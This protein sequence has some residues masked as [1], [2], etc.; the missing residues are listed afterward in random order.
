MLYPAQSSRI[1][2][3]ISLMPLSPENSEVPPPKPV[4]VNRT[5]Q[6]SEAELGIDRWTDEAIVSSPPPI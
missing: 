6:A 5:M 3:E 2:F 1:A 4:E